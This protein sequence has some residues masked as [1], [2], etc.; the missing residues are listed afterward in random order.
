MLMVPALASAP[1]AQ[2]MGKVCMVEVMM[3]ILMVMVE[4]VVQAATLCLF[5]RSGTRTSSLR[6]TFSVSCLGKQSVHLSHCHMRTH[7]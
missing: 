2:A 6:W 7:E 3:G 1:E 4:Q 5:F